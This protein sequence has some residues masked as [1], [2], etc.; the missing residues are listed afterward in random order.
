MAKAA[1]L[2]DIDGTLIDSDPLHA[3]VFKD[4]MA[5]RGVEVDRAFYLAN[6][7]GRHNTD[8]FRDLLPDEDARAMHLVKEAAFREILPDTYPSIPGA[9]ELIEGAL[10]QDI[11]VAA[12]T[13]APRLNAE[14][15]LKAT[16]L[17]DHVSII[18][19]G[20][21]CA[22]GKPAPDPYLEALRHFDLSAAQAIAFEDSPSG[23]VSARAAGITTVGVR[24]SLSDE[25]LRAEGCA[26][27]VADL[28]DPVLRPTLVSVAG[29]AS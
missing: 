12:V 2:F 16:G 19:V 5:K 8:I 29:W 20:E 13:N 10:R 17:L 11:A 4:I 18:V 25:R 3:Q 1:L 21:E 26:L 15:M 23:I 24:S 9:G 7:H 6:I 28:S 27:S 14:A 22:R